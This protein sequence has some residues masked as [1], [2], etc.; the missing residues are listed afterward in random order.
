[1]CDFFFSKAKEKVSQAKTNAGDVKKSVDKALEDISNIVRELNNL[2]EIGK[3]ISS[4]GKF[5][6]SG[7]SRLDFFRRRNYVK[8]INGEITN[9]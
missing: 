8:S 6:V 2:P 9:R 5:T 1:M 3:T 7:D 4:A